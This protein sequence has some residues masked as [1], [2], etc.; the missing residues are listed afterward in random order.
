MKGYVYI[1]YSEIIIAGDFKQVKKMICSFPRTAN[2]MVFPELYN[3]G[4]IELDVMKMINIL[5]NPNIFLFNSM[6]DDDFPFP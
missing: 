2:S 1:L 3:N 4:E 5:H 6:Q